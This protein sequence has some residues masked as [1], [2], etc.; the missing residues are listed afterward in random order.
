[1]GSQAV[2]TFAGLVPGKH[3]AKVKSEFPPGILAVAILGAANQGET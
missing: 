1:M 3:F 2:N